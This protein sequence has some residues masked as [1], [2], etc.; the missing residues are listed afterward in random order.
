[1]VIRKAKISEIEK[2]KQ[3]FDS[4]KEMDIILE[5]FPKNYYKRILEKG[6][7]IVAVESEELLGSCFGTYNLKEKWADL[8]GLAVKKEFQKQR[9]GSSLIKEFEMICKEKKLK[10]I[11]LYSDKAQINLFEKLKYTK[12]R[13]YTSFRKKL[14]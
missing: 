12:E 5:T 13:T 3:L 1:M 9:I 2:I 14:K 4:F 7:L 6:I 8:L 11:D 10:T